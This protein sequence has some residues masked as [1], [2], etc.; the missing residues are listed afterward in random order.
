MVSRIQ[1]PLSFDAAALRE[2]VARLDAD[3]WVPHFNTA[4][5]EG[6]WSGVALRS[7]GGRPTQ[8]YPD[9]AASEPYA[10]TPTLQ[11]CPHLAH[12]LGQFQ[13]ELLSARLLR[14]GPKA[15]IREHQD[16]NLGYDDGEVRIHVPLTTSPEVEFRHAGDRVDMQPG[17]A[18]YLDLNLPHAVA[19]HGDTERVHLVIDCV[20]DSWL[21]ELLAAGST[22]PA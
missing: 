12:A 19:N 1:V 3:E 7:V 21:D 22:R 11:R 4:Y 2:D 15:L 9:P 8:L 20:L 18:W 14:L 17:E 16:Y 13:C 5:Y 6:D 10:D